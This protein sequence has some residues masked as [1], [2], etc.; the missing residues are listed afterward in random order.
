MN[1]FSFFL[2]ERAN[3]ACIVDFAIEEYEAWHN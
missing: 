3:V 1:D 2:D